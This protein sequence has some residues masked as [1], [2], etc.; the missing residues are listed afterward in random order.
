[1][2]LASGILSLK[3]FQ[4]VVA[5]ESFISTLG[6]ASCELRK[7]R[8]SFSSRVN[9]RSSSAFELVYSNVGLRR[10]PSVKGFSIFS[11]LLMTSLALLDF[12]C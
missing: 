2:A 8:V 3:K 12:I 6:C 11:F 5:I 10:V 1:M 7:H 4:S 9:N